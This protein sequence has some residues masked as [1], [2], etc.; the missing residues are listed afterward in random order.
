MEHLKIYGDL[1]EQEAIEQIYTLAKSDAYKDNIIRVMPD[2]HA[3]AGCTVG[4]TMIITDK[5]T[6]NLVGVDI[7]CTVS[8]WKI[9]LPKKTNA[10]QWFDTVKTKLD[11]VIHE[12]IPAGFAIRKSLDD[13]PKEIV[14]RVSNLNFDADVD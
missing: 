3:G 5:I 7:G 4:T 11:D 1:I 10:K 13:V 14:D 8:A 9:K 2:C 6:P 12:H